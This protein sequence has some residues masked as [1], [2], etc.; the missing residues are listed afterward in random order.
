MSTVTR[1]LKPGNLRHFSCT[2]NWDAMDTYSTL[3]NHICPNLTGLHSFKLLCLEPG[4]PSSAVPNASLIDD[5]S[6]IW[7][8]FPYLQ[9]L[10]LNV[11][12]TV[13]RN[14]LV[15]LS[16]LPLRSLALRRF[17]TSVASQSPRIQFIAL[18]DLSLATT[19]SSVAEF[20]QSISIP[21]ATGLF[22]DVDL[23]N[24]GTTPA[25]FSELNA[26][27]STFPV[28]LRRVRIGITHRNVVRVKEAVG[29]GLDE[30]SFDNFVRPLRSL[31]NLRELTLHPHLTERYVGGF[32]DLP[33]SDFRSLVPSWP[34]L[35]LFE[36][37]LLTGDYMRDGP[38]LDTIFAFARAHPRLLH[39]QLPYMCTDD[40][41]RESEVLP[42][43]EDVPPPL[44]GHGLLWL[45]IG[46][47]PDIPNPTASLELPAASVLAVDRAFPQVRKEIH[48]SL[49]L[50][51]QLEEYQWHLFE[52]ELY[53]LQ[54]E[55]ETHGEQW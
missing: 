30:I 51:D 36:Y 49:A 12:F 29:L 45:K 48:R 46:S 42:P 14:M 15:S 16:E 7:R 26:I 21:N 1:L 28:S 23:Y 2:L 20:M 4:Y 22:L 6:L 10:E 50:N 27:Y 18:R 53:A 39:L 5:R 25:N 9:S 38:T 35:E 13:T 19:A 33:D 3:L 24:N 32:L 43:Q 55:E 40:L 34:E 17:S 31:R 47:D 52:K 37:I 44:E 8:C 41:L 11:R 54:G